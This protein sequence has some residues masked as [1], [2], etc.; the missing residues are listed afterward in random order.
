M[1]DVVLVPTDGSEASLRAADE[2]FRIARET[3]AVVHALYV[4]D[5]SA[6]SLIFADRPMADLLEALGEEGTAAVA[7]VADRATAL[8]ADADV[9]ADVAADVEV[10]TDVVRGM[11][12]HEAILEYA[13]DH[14]VDLVVM[15][16]HGRKGLQHL[17]G[18]TTERVI[19]N[20]FVPVLVVSEGEGDR[21]TA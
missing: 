10:V 3:G 2:A 9:D 17:L 5:E 15:G 11:Q 12:I 1:Y 16:T 4:I 13:A 14:D 20:S 6:S 21:G 8:N 19:A 7:A 18:S